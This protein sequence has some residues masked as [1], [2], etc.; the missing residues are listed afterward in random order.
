MADI[1]ELQNSFKTEVERKQFMVQQHETIV[2]LMQ[3]NKQLEE[4]ILHLKELLINLSQ[5]DH[6]KE[7]THTILVTPEEGLI[8]SQIQMITNR[9]FEREMSL[10]DT[11]RLDLLIKNK[12]IIKD[13]SKSIEVGNKTVDRKDLT[14]SQLV[15]I[16]LLTKK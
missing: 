2:K 4:N 6:K 5:L 8:D 11:K 1:I 12:K 14:H 3:K 15:Q 9:C 16:A 13:D 7:E 10:E